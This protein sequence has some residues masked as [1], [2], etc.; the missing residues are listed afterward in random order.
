MQG[1]EVSELMLIGFSD[2]GVGVRRCQR[3]DK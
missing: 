3:E 1:S 2:V